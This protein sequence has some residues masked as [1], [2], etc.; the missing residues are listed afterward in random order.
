MPVP[1]DDQVQDQRVRDLFYDLS[2]AGL[3]ASVLRRHRHNDD[4]GLLV[5]LC[6]QLVDAASEMEDAYDDHGLHILGQVRL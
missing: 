2:K 5:E 4:T 6:R 1:P 3:V